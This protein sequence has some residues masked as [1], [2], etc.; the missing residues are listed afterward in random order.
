MVTDAE[1][2]RALDV[3]KMCVGNWRRAG[4]PT[5]SVRAAKAWALENARNFRLREERDFEARVTDFDAPILSISRPRLAV[6]GTVSVN[7]ARSY[8]RRAVV[9]GS[10]LTAR[11][12][13]GREKEKEILCVEGRS[14]AQKEYQYPSTGHPPPRLHRNGR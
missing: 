5:T 6:A 7:P 11:A 8:R 3:T 2:A 1:I 9:S 10:G 4:C 12:T 13:P 14:P